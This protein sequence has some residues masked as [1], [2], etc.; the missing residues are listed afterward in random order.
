MRDVLSKHSSPCT[1]I[2]THVIRIFTTLVEEWKSIAEYERCIG[3]KNDAV[4]RSASK[5]LDK[6]GS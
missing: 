2:D 1:Q 5:V 6:K 4:R 3:W